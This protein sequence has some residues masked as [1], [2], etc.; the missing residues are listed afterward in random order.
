MSFFVLLALVAGVCAALQGPTN[1]A[2]AARSGLARAILANM[3]LAFALSIGMWAV[4]RAPPPEPDR[5]AASPL[6]YLGGIYGFAIVATSA[7]AVARL[8]AASTLTL[9]VAAQAATALLLDH[10]GALGLERAPVSAAR[11]LGLALV[12]AGAWLVQR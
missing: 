9:I 1:A 3:A 4:F 7:V 12:V 6:H 5:G 10:L 8:G 11:L 2:L